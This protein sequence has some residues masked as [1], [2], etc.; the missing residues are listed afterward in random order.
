MPKSMAWMVSSEDVLELVELQAREAD[1]AAPPCHRPRWSAERQKEQ[2]GQTYGRA[3]RGLGARFIGPTNEGGVIF[4]VLEPWQKRL[5][6]LI[7][8]VQ[9][10][11]P[12]LRRQYAWAGK[13]TGNRPVEN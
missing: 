1:G 9:T 7:L 13:E 12:G 6:F 11:F 8:K 5:G 2:P 10:E 3:D 4:P